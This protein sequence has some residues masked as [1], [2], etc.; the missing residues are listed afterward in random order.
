MGA[1]PVLTWSIIIAWLTLRGARRASGHHVST[2]RGLLLGLGLVSLVGMPTQDPAVLM[3]F[4]LLVAMLATASPGFGAADTARTRASLSRAWMIVGALA[5]AYAGGHVALA[6]GSLNVAERAASTNRDYIV[7]LY[8]EE[9]H[10]DGGQFQW[11][12]GEARLRLVKRTPWLVVRTWIQ[13]PDASSERPVTLSVVTPCQVVF[14]RT[15]VDSIPVEF[16]LRL[17]NTDDRIDLAVRVSRTWS[18][19]SFG[20]SDT[21]ELG[22]GLVTDFVDSAAEASAPSTVAMEACGVARPTP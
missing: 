14:E 7:G 10:P 5:A 20:S 4:F 21:R 22:A 9:P 2:V 11:T 6:G 16:V 3:A 15:L 12:G 8:R 1:L 19:A 13:H 17:P 18:P